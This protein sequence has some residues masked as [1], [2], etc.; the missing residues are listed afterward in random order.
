MVVRPLGTQ[1]DSGARQTFV[2]N[3]L[4][5][6]GLAVTEHGSPVAVIASSRGGYAEHAARAVADLRDGGAERVLVAGRSSE[7]GEH[8]D[9]VDGELHDGMDVV[10][11]LDDL[12]TRLERRGAR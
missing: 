6:G 5:A 1:R 10:A 11:V 3:L 9:L 12:L 7:L 8:A 2:R 4:G